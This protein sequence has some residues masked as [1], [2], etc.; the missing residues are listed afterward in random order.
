MTTKPKHP[1]DAKIADVLN[2]NVEATEQIAATA[3]E[4]VV[5]HA[6]LSSHVPAK[7]A[8][9]DLE[10]A[11]ERTGEIEQQLSETAKALDE[12]NKLLREID[13]NQSGKASAQI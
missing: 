4:L 2:Q 5:V 3:T 9:G 10:A 11:V 8:K 1:N 6:V 7:S 12:S 13:S